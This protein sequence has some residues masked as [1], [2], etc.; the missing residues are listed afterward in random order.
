MLETVEYVCAESLVVVFVFLVG[1]VLNEYRWV[2]VDE[3]A[4]NALGAV[5][6]KVY[7]S[8]RTVGAVAAAYHCHALPSTR[9]GIEPVGLLARVA[10]LHLDE[11]GCKHRVPLSVNVMSE[12]RTLVTPLAEVFNRCRPHA[13]VWSAIACVSHIVRADDVSA[14]LPRVVGVFKNARFTIGHMFPQWQIR[15]LSRTGK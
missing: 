15:I 8:E 9:V 6:S 1:N 4:R 14:E 11:V 3:R 12:D 13:D 5:F 7:G 2:E 10:V